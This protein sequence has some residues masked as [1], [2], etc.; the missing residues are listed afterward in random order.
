M[1]E[2]KQKFLGQTI[3]IQVPS[4][5][6]EFDTLAG[7]VGACV[8]SAVAKEVLHGYGGKWRNKYAEAVEKAFKDENGEPLV[9][10]PIDD[11]ATANAPAKKDGTKTPVHISPADYLDL[12]K[13]KTGKTDADLASIAQD[14]AD[15]LPF[16]LKT[17]SGGSARVSKGNLEMANSLLAA[18]DRCKAAVATLMGRNEGLD[19]AVD[20]ETGLPTAEAL[21]L[22]LAVDKA[23]RDR[24]EMA[25]LGLV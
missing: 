14:T 2:Y 13:A 21:A 7:E 16:D 20:T 10:W 22:G 19:I 9:P 4:T 15:A 23:R 17:S 12:F 18:P 5:P 1:K 3:T 24:E 6:E 11:D 8:D 25:S